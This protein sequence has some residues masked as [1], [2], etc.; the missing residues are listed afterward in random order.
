M[1]IFIIISLLV[2]AFSSCDLAVFGARSSSR[3]F[4]LVTDDIS[5][6]PSEHFFYVNIK[7]AYY[8]GA[9]G[10]FDPLDFQLYAMDQ[11]P[12]TDCKIS[13]SEQSS[14]EDLYCMLDIMEGDLYLHEIELDYNVP[15]EMCAYLGFIPHWHYNQEVGEGPKTVEHIVGEDDAPDT[16]RCRKEITKNTE[17][18]CKKRQ[19]GRNTEDNSWGVWYD[20][21]KSHVPDDY[22]CGVKNNR[23][24]EGCFTTTGNNEN[25]IQ[26]NREENIPD[27][28]PTPPIRQGEAD[29]E[30]SCL[31][32]LEACDDDTT[33]YNTEE[34]V[35][36]YNKESEDSKKGLGN[37]CLGDYRLFNSENQASEEK[38][39]GGNIEN[40]IGG[41]ARI[42]WSSFND[43]GFPITSIRQSASRGVRD[44]YTLYPLID[45][46]KGRQTFPTAN[47]FKNIERDKKTTD[48][49]AFY[50]ANEGNKD[51]C[52][53]G[54]PCPKGHP[55]LTWSCFD[56]AKEVRHRIHLLIREWNTIAEFTKFKES[57]G[58]RGDPDITGDEGKLCDYFTPDYINT[59]DFVDY[60]FTDCNDL[61]DADDQ[62]KERRDGKYK[63]P[64]LRY[65]GR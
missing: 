3:Q 30:Y 22:H 57:K 33:I 16:Y 27:P 36:P 46:V 8:T 39:W 59:G 49:P 64:E 20:W 13:A 42:E 4:S 53:K 52:G 50:K 6:I 65:E 55:F 40:C 7:S 14:T 25:T 15:P 21:T 45:K 48:L 41:L 26:Y 61:R 12:G 23:P 29:T 32:D 51:G 62:S 44:Q 2:L 11:G 19:R 34:G 38:E 35:C 47:F 1:K 9:Q 56:K 17:I 18:S 5:D 10:S 28:L 37:C 31:Y 54:R 63:Y 43:T 24:A 60:S 58:G